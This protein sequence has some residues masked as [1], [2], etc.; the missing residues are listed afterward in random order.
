MN[1]IA[2][3]DHGAMYG[4]IEFVQTAKKYDVKPIIGMEAYLA[5]EGNDKKR[6]KIDSSPRHL[7][8]LAQ[9]NVGYKNLMKL[10]TEA[11][12][13]GYYYKPR[14]DY[15]LLEKY[16][17]GLIVL[18]GCMNG[19]IPKAIQEK[20]DEDVDRLVKWHLDVFGKDRFYFEVQHHQNIPAQGL[21]NE[22]VIALS[23][24]HG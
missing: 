23:K 5:P 16:S 20:R 8:I 6:G 21:L 15:H 10:S 11:F 1:S 24:K 19:D 7:T 9:N 3:T 22:K 2:L 12:L 13:H 17:E 18:S 4:I 14:I